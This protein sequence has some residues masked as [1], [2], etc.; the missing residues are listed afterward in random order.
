MFDYVFSYNYV[1]NAYK[2]ELFLP[3]ILK[4]FHNIKKYVNEQKIIKLT[5]KNID[6]SRRKLNSIRVLLNYVEVQYKTLTAT[7]LEVSRG[8][9]RRGNVLPF[10]FEFQKSF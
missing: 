1:K 9:G 7:P 10:K 4:Q 2:A 8:T 3:K 5:E 6:T